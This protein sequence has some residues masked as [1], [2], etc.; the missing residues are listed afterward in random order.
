TEE[1]KQNFTPDVRASLWKSLD[2]DGKRRFLEKA[3]EKRTA[4]L[5]VKRTG[6]GRFA[7][8][9]ERVASFRLLLT[10]E[11]FDPAK[12]VHVLFNGRLHEKKPKPDPRGLAGEFGDRLD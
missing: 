2:E 10:A 8:T 3:V 6:P 5:E 11:M 4:R 9:G 12:P 7:A 1:L